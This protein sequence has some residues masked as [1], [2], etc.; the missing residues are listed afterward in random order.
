MIPEICKAHGIRHVVCSPGSR[1]APLL[2]AFHHQE[3]IE[4]HVAVDERS[5]AFI[6]L[7]MSQHLK[8][9]V[10]MVCTSGTALLNYAP[11]V[12]EAFYRAI[13]LV[14]IS[15]DRP[16]EWIDQDD[17]QTIRQPGTLSNFVKN[18]YDIPPADG[19]SETEWFANRMINDAMITALTGRRGPVHI[20]VRLREPLHFHPDYSMKCRTIKAVTRSESLNESDRE[21]ISHALK[22]RRILFVFG[23]AMKDERTEKLAR[24]L[25]A[26]PQAWVMS[27]T[28]SN[29][30]LGDNHSKIDT[31]LT[32]LTESDKQNLRPDLV[33]TFGGALIS[34]LLKTFLREYPAKEHWSVGDCHTTVDCFRT[35]SRRIELEPAEFLQMLTENIDPDPGSDYRQ[36][37]ENKVANAIATHESYISGIPWSDMKA[38]ETILKYIPQRYSLHLSNGTAVRYAQLLTI[39]N[40]YETFCNRGVSGIDGSTSTAI[41][42]ATVSDHPSVLLTGDLSFSYDVGALSFHETPDSF[43]IIVFNNQG[44]GIFRFIGSTSSLPQDNLERYFCAFPTV[45]YSALAQAYGYEYILSEDESSLKDAMIH[46]DDPRKRKLLIEV[47]TDGVLSAEILRNYMNR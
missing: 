28:V 8:E 24:K 18:S 10:A 4:T 45:D 6:A 17:S 23:C 3:G 5:A 2:L 32:T 43:T 15:A 14:V 11:A 20:N 40:Q 47:R 21:E 9:A 39:H 36:H 25:R 35:L 46:I 19:S 42:T 7:G 37:W 33:I 1:N 27:E 26:L 31:V 16:L 22:G 41:G 34:R 38:F 29:V 44:G 13:P 30:W 12:A